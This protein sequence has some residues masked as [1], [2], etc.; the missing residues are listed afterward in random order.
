MRYDRDDPGFERVAT[1]DIETTHY[2]A[3]EGETVSIGIGVHER[4]APG[5]DAAYERYHREEYDEAQL[6]ERGLKRLDELGVDGVVSFNGNDFDL[7]FLRDRLNLLNRAT[8]IPEIDALETHIDLFADRKAVCNRTGQKW[9][10]LE[11]C[12]LS[13]G[14]DEP[15]TRWNGSPVTN[16]RFGEE[17]GPAYLQALSNANHDRIEQ[18]RAVIDHYL[19]TDLEANLA[20]FYADIG[21]PFEPA[22]L[23][24][25]R[26]F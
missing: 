7:G 5:E 8:A 21:Y 11:E 25:S 18:L 9:P 19:V 26:S 3:S 22:H 13:Y 4:G 20:V 24:T 6:I 23:G 17:L 16:V 14:L 10:K 12:L 15:E 2:K 1:F